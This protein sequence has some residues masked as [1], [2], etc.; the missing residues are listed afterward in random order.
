MDDRVAAFLRSEAVRHGFTVHSAIVGEIHLQDEAPI[1]QSVGAVYG[2]WANSVC[3]PTPRGVST[4]PSDSDW[5]PVYW[6]KDIRPCSR[7]LAHVQD[8]EGTGNVKLAEIEELLGRHLL[9]GA[10]LVSDYEGFESH[11][12][13]NY[14]PLKGSGRRGKTSSLVVIVE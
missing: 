11:L 5:F 14:K 7:I 3:K 6:G 2:I 13:K 4:I 1:R 12:H 8:H 10:I 9:F